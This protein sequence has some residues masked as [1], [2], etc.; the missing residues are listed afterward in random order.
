MQKIKVEKM[1]IGM[2]FLNAKKLKED[3]CLNFINIERPNTKHRFAKLLPIIV[4]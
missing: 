3:L 1:L 2:K 4:P